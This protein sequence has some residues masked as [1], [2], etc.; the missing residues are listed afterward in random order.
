MSTKPISPY[1]ARLQA[2]LGII[3]ET[4]RLIDLWTPG[5]SASQL[6]GVAMDAG[7]F[8]SIS[9]RRLR[10]VV[11]EAFGTRYLTDGGQPAAFLKKIKG[12]ID[13]ADFRQ[14]L[15]VYTCR[16][17]PVLADFVREIYWTRYEAGAGLIQKS[18][19]HDFIVRAVADSRT[20]TQWSETTV[21]RVAKYLLGA[22]ADFGL[23]GGIRGE[24]RVITP[25]RITGTTSLFL[26][27]EVHFR[28]FG[29]N[30]IVSHADW[31]LF[32]LAPE[33][34]IGE[35][36]RLAQKG[37]FILQSAGGVTHISWRLKSMEEVAD[38]LAAG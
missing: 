31:G 30:S 32:G 25:Y 33:D 27:H 6:A 17:N 37:V 4:S 22:I 2:G 13:S 34:V 21:S 18:D 26:A 20:T 28:G 35:L 3:P 7:A 8:P 29:D 11:V 9:A 14:I 12:K 1:S 36:K 10:N 19:A 5:L 16:A 38:V 15:F 24:G 23:V